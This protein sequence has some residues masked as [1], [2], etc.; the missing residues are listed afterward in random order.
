MIADELFIAFMS[1]IA[2]A[3]LTFFI[4]GI[5][6]WSRTPD[7]VMPGSERWIWLFIIVFFNTIGAI[8]F[9][10]KTRGTRAP[11]KA[12]KPAPEGTT[13]G[14]LQ[15]TPDTNPDDIPGM[16]YQDKRWK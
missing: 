4:I 16:I 11:I 5:I 10:I 6:A 13:Y 2:L 12:P 9:L 8:L 7:H 3:H 15:I 1:F 14:S